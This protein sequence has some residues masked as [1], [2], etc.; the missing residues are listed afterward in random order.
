M[1]RR[2]YIVLERQEL[3]RL[4]HRSFLFPECRYTLKRQ[5][6]GVV[7]HATLSSTLRWQPGDVVELED[8]LVQAQAS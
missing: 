1:T 6:D 2:K 4:S 5:D 8:L 3:P 7:Y